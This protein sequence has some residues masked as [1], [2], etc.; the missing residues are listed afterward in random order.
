M[1]QVTYEQFGEARFG[2]V[3]GGSIIDMARARVPEGR[4]YNGG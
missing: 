2:A 4:G 3:V 1:K